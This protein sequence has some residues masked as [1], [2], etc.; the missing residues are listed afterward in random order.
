[1][2]LF[3]HKGIS[4]SNAQ[5]IRRGII[6]GQIYLDHIKR[7]A[8]YMPAETLLYWSARKLMNYRAGI[9]SVTEEYAFSETVYRGLS[10]CMSKE[11]VDEIFHLSFGMGHH[12]L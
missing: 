4:T 7:L 9:H 8:T 1:M 3:K 11:Q 6:T 5:R 12:M 2:R 10:K